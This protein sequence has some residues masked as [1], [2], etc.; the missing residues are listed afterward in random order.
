MFENSNLK[1]I[2]LPKE[3]TQTVN[4]TSENLPKELLDKIRTGNVEKIVWIHM[5]V[6]TIARYIKNTN[7]TAIGQGRKGEWYAVVTINFDTK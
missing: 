7:L 5:T 4:L 3:N 1:K 6:K 2:F